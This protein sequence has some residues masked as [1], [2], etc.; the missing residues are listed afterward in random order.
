V[1]LLPRHEATPSGELLDMVAR[2][3]EAL[4]P[5]KTPAGEFLLSL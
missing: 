3:F 2:G 1:G 5:D 4:D